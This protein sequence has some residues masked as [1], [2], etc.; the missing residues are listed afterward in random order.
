MKNNTKVLN[1][2]LF[3]IIGFLFLSTSVIS[4]EINFKANE[5]L[6]YE[7]GDLIVGKDNAEAII[8]GEI[9]IYADIVT[10]NKKNETLI[11]EGNVLVVDQINK[12]KINS[13]KINYDKIK[14]QLLSEDKT[15]FKINDEYEIESYDVN[16]KINEEEIFS[17]KETNVKD[18]IGNQINLISFK[19]FNKTQTLNGKEI[20]IEDNEKNK[21]FL[22]AG[23]IRLQNFELLGKDI[24]VL[25]RNDIYGNNE[26]EPK[27]VGNSVNYYEDKTI[28]KKGIF[29][30]CAE[31]NNCP[32]W[33][34][35][36]KEIIHYKKQ[37]EIHYKHAWLRLYNTPVFYF[38]KFFHPD[39]SVDRKSGFLIPTFSDSK[40][41]GASV[42]VPYFHVISESSDLTFKPRF[43]S[44]SEYL[45][46]SEF[47]KETKNS[48]HIADFSINKD[49]DKN[50]TKTHFFSNSIF[51]LNQNFFD[52]SKINLKLEKVSN[53]DFTKLYSLESTSPIIKDTN[54]LEN[55]F[56]FSG[57]RDDLDFNLSF[58]SYE[59]MN[60]LNS[61]KYEFVYPNYSLSKAIDLE[62][63]LIESLD[64][65]S[66]GNQK[67]FSTN[68]YEATQV[69]DLILTSSKFI[70]KLGF[71]NR[72]KSIIK[73]V[74]SDANNSS[75]L[76][77][78]KQS[79]LLT[80]ISYELDLP[81]IKEEGDY[82]NFLIPKLALRFSPN[83]SKNLKDE[84]R[85]LTSDNIFSLNRIGFNETIEGG[86]SLTLGVN[87][88]KKS[89]KKG[90]LFDAKIATVFRD[91][92]NENLPTSSTLG[93]KQSD[94][95]G[96]LR[97]I[98]NS[99]FSFDYNFSVDNDLDQMNL[100]SLENTFT[101]NNFVNTFTFYEENNIVGKKSYYEN[102]LKYKINKRN[103]FSFKTRENKTDNLTEYYN[104]IY[105]YKNDCLTASITY[106]KDYYSSGNIKP[107]EELFFNITLIPLGSTKTDSIL[108]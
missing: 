106:N 35:T 84:N 23:I 103:S 50:G 6:S 79:E 8:D 47:R 45:L 95:V 64:F 108:E 53:D 15:F 5:I 17:D 99:K 1:L 104:L 92:L 72:L 44:T 83:D 70:N 89:K 29:T 36:S 87:Y 16:Y 12:I 38:P 42:N 58:E 56:E 27:L 39:P 91:E 62:S 4:K 69:N 57:T 14:N 81:L 26:N 19:Y 65:S 98:P 102:T 94:Y 51:N 59:S 93:K 61:D 86:G 21:Y 37:K 75:K 43:F 88:E 105:E 78:K 100:H 71:N 82:M 101:V 55:I 10:Y 85:L 66:I 90:H 46:Q 20:K 63:D 28:V 97:Y 107:N 7:E 24:K 74:N 13:N 25:L 3:L 30:S 60:K 49:E 73:N 9:E 52:N 67:K 31:N 40:S 32:P 2:F 18:K 11:A 77:E 33:S 76:K 80:L 96:E 48:S 68:I 54:I 22:K 34:I 41:L